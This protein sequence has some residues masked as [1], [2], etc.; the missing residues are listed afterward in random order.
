MAHLWPG[1]IVLTT[2]DAFLSRAIRWATRRPGNPS[3]VNHAALVVGSGEDG[4]AS[5]V[6][7][8]ATVQRHTINSRYHGTGTRIQVW[9]PLNLSDAQL[10]A[11]ADYAESQV[12]QRYD[13]LKIGLQLV[14]GL[15]GKVARREVCFAR[16]L[17]FD[18]RGPI[19]SWLVAQAYWRGAG[20]DFGLPA[21]APDPDDL[22][23]YCRE[24][25]E[26]Y[27][28]VRPPSPL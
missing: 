2:G 18:D 17:G 16:R 23:D 1:D 6:E 5:I 24:H 7:A 4:R 27:Y 15:L 28:L 21:R 10:L 3:E 8:L 25:P 9:R 22:L 20:L 11:I 12:G 19:C 14:D 26:H 13:Y